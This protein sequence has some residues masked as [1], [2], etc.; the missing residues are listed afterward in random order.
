MD[1]SS[2]QH[3]YVEGQARPSFPDLLAG[4]DRRSSQGRAAGGWRLDIAYGPHERET[5]DLL[6]A[7]GGA[8]GTVVYFHAGYWQARD[9]SQ[10]HFLADGFNGLGWDMAFVN[11]PL[12]P[13]VTVAQ[14]VE[15]AARALERV[16]ALYADDALRGPLVL[17]GH[18]AGAHLAVELALR[19]AAAHAAALPPIAGVLAVSGIYDLRP[20]RQTSLNE[21]LRLDEESATACSPL[22]RPSAGC[23]P[24]LFVVG[25]TETAA[26]HAQTQDMAQRWQARGNSTLCLEAPGHD[27]FSL[28]DWIT[29]RD[30]PVDR[31]LRG[32]V[33]S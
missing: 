24:A 22:L 7:P 21:R 5:L 33:G 26:F 9:K 6:A 3:Q 1:P 13:Q 19:D 16:R 11:Y 2:A 20:L 4:F 10:F 27:H 30:A 29:Q 18:S 12:C 31:E 23:A 14:I 32:W 28:L 17:C 25:G 8:R 15:S